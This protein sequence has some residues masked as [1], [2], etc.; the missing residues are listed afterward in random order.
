MTALSIPSIRRVLSYIGLVIV[1]T[2]AGTFAFSPVAQAVGIEVRP[3]IMDVRPI[4]GITPITIT[5]L[6]A[7]LISGGGPFPPPP[8][9]L[10]RPLV[11]A[12]PCDKDRAY[13]TA[14]G[15]IDHYRS[16]DCDQ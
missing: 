2:V 16:Q 5:R 11:A 10:P 7:P 12:P 13:S 6:P 3:P 8:A 9:E 15:H 14:D 1:T 4:T